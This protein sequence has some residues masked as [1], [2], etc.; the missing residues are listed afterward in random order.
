[1]LFR[2]LHHQVQ[3]ARNQ[4]LKL[5]FTWVAASIQKCQTQIHFQLF[6]NAQSGKN[7]FPPSLPI[8]LM[9]FILFNVLQ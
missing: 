2:P 1:M 3:I 9:Q 8:R 6:L 5:I 7:Q 4:R